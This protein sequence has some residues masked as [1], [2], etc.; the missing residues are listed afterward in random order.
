MVLSCIDLSA[1]I[2][3]S[4]ASVYLEAATVYCALHARVQMRAKCSSSTTSECII[5][6]A[7]QMPC[8]LRLCAANN[9]C[10]QMPRHATNE[11]SANV[12]IGAEE[13]QQSSNRSAAFAGH[14]SGRI[15]K[16]THRCW[17]SLHHST[18]IVLICSCLCS[19]LCYRPF[20]LLQRFL[21]TPFLI[22]LLAFSPVDHSIDVTLH[23]VACNTA[24]K[25]FAAG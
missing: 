3:C 17:C 1:R 16:L 9:Q 5:N 19:D 23:T 24:C 12:T 8:W 4:V 25:C 20:K 2:C 15:E 11:G 21:Y 7:I 18:G 22:I 13:L 14:T 6:A 10:H